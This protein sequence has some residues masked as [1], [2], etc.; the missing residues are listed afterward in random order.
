MKSFSALAL[1]AA[2]FKY[3]KIH[4]SISIQSAV[5]CVYN[6][7]ANNPANGKN[8]NNE[9]TITKQSLDQ[10]EFEILK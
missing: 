2:L 6:I 8:N 3:K 9:V 5:Y 1:L 7:K 10:F 4:K